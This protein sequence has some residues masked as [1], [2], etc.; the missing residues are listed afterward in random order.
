MRSTNRCPPG[1]TPP[2]PVFCVRRPEPDARRTHLQAVRLPRPQ[3]RQGVGKRLPEAAPPGR[4]VEFRPRPVALPTRTTAPPQGTPPP[5][6]LR[7]LPE[8][9]RRRQPTRPRPRAAGPR[10]P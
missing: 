10:H 2:E 7:R 3:D 5:V 9:D 4:R 6:A 1:G 8:A